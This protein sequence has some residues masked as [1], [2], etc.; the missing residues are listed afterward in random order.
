MEKNSD[1]T[2]SH[3]D[4]HILP[5]SWPFVISR[6]QCACSKLVVFGIHRTGQNAWRLE[7]NIPRTLLM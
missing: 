5:V 7:K 3:S 4:E 6:F 1:I 2:N